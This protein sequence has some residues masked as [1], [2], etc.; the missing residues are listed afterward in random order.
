MYS[1]DRRQMRQPFLDAWRKTRDRLPMTGIELK[2]SEVIVQHPEYHDLLDHPDQALERDWLPEQGEVNPFLHMGFHLS[3]REMVG[4]D[5]PG[6]I[7]PLYE[8][9]CLQYGD[10]LAAEHAMMDCLSEAIWRAQR[11]NLPPDGAALLTC[12][13][14]LV[15]G[16]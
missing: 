12:I 15:R 6:G 2:I 1:N 13:Q 16:K 4:I 14:G 3:I 9:L 7:R 10:P 11:D 8:R 5:Q